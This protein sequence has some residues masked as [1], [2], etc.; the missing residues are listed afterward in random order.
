M[1]SWFKH[2]SSDYMITC[3]RCF[4]DTPH[5]ALIA[6]VPCPPPSSVLGDL[7]NGPFAVL[8][9]GISPCD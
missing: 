4:N 8:E 3:A 2:V 7:T 9:K 5:V 6:G 1:R